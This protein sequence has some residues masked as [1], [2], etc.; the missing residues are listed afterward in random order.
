MRS[1]TSNSYLDWF[2]R[3][4]IPIVKALIVSNALTFLA[5]VFADLRS[6]AQFVVFEPVNAASRIWTLVTYPFWAGSGDVISILFAC[7]WLWVAGGSLER[8]WD[9]RR[10]AT[11]FASMS[12][13]SALGLWAGSV[14]SGISIGAAGLWLPL[15]GLTVAFA[16]RDPEQQILLFFVVPLKLKYLALLDIVIVL[17]SYARLSPICGILA[18]TGCGYSY[19]YVK[20]QTIP[21]GRTRYDKGEVIRVHSRGSLL[22]RLNPVNWYRD[23]RVRKRLRDLFDK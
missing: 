18:L 4:R 21:F 8:G 6:V 9:S 14:F 10:F 5:S 13:V 15:A 11:Y 19:L 7:Y 23:Y 12:A 22:R 17:T 2:I 3:D 20:R 16:A 1:Y